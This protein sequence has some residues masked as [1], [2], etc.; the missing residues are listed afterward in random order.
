MDIS[1]YHLHK[2]DDSKLHFQIKDANIHLAKNPQHVYKP[3][4]HTYYQMIWFKEA[5][6]HYVDYILH[7]HPA[8]SLFLLNKGQIHYFCD[9]ASNVGQLYHFDEIFL[10]KGDQSYNNRIQYELFSERNQPYLVLNKE[11]IKILQQITPLLVEE[12]NQMKYGYRDQIFNLLQIIIVTIERQK[13]SDGN[14]F[15][16]S[17]ENLDIAM[18]FKNLIN[19]N[20]GSFLSVQEYA[21]MMHVSAKKLTAVCRSYLD[22]TPANVIAQLKILEAKRMLSNSNTS[23]KEVAYDL[24]FDQATYFTKYFKK[25]TNITPKEFVSQWQS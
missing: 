8:N 23:I 20:V 19:Q 24:G 2:G 18:D 13:K 11:S 22:T 7:H 17:N 6:Q 3:H 25:H 10:L 5:G 16:A 9:H 14:H 1:Q 15:K 4:R 12:I 21:K